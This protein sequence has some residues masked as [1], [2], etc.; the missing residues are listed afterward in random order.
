MWT[1]A[2]K[3]I[4]NLQISLPYDHNG[5]RGVIIVEVLTICGKCSPIYIGSN[6]MKLCDYLVPQISKAI[7]HN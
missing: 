5:H 3:I 1:L 2:R 7:V 4:A 6:I